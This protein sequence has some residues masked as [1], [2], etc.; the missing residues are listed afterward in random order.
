[1]SD[2]NKEDIYIIEEKEDESGFMLDTIINWTAIRRSK[3]TLIEKHNFDYSM[4]LRELFSR[5]NIIYFG[6]IIGEE[7]I[8]IEQT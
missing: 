5:K 7:P 6:K 8:P 4:S 2:L 3:F 1:M